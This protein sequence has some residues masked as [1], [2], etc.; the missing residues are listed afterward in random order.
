[1]GAAQA[2]PGART[3]GAVVEIRDGHALDLGEAVQR[4]ALAQVPGTALE[5]RRRV[6]AVVATQPGQVGGVDA[7]GELLCRPDVEGAFLV[8]AVGVQRGGEAP[9]AAGHFLLQP[10]DD[11]D[12]R[13]PR[14]RVALGGTARVQR[15][16][17]GVV[18]QHLLEVRDAPVG[19][20]AVAE[21]AAAELVLQ[22]AFGHPL[23]TLAQVRAQAVVAVALQYPQFHRMGKLRRALPAA[24]VGVGLAAPVGQGCLQRRQRQRPL[25]R[26]LAAVVA[27]EAGQG[28]RLLGAFGRAFGIPARQALQHVAEGRQAVPCLGRKIGADEKGH[29]VGR[30]EEHG[31]RP[32]AAAALQRLVGQLVDAV[33]VGAFFPIKLDVQEVRI[34][35]RRG[36]WIGKTL[37]RHHV[38]PVA[39][40]V[41]DR[42]QDRLAGGARGGQRI[43]APGVPVDR[44][45]PM[46]A[47]VEAGRG[48][49][50]VRHG[51]LP[52]RR[53]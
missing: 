24:V 21:E 26:R 6:E 29:Q 41:A 17:Q 45:L 32:A 47:Q 40:G 20:D 22:A 4:P 12:R 35:Q 49:E 7:G 1:L 19:V 13:A 52:G 38:A 11:A 16:Q 31:Q 30:V 51:V 48:G 37:A 5:V 25:L 14:Q 8:A 28:L 43:V 46:L 39:G 34:H 33:E 42:Q 23:Q 10:A 44:V 53:V 18:G 36:G 27:Q 50:A 9:L 2:Q 15:Q 3:L